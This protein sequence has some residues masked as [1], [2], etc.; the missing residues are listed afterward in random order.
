MLT[1][2]KKNRKKKNLL[3]VM[4]Y[5]TIGGIFEG[6]AAAVRLYETAFGVRIVDS[7]LR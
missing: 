6:S 7:G 2:H 4:D 3:L 5:L 1:K